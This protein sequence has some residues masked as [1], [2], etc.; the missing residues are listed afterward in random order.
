MEDLSVQKEESG[1]D[2]EGAT[3][4]TVVQRFQKKL[5]PQENDPT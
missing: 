3:I 4:R 1:T 2:G 5:T